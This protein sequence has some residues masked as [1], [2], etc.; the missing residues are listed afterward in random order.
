MKKLILLIMVSLLPMVC[1]AQLNVTST[2]EKMVTLASG[3]MGNISMVK[4]GDFY[5]MHISSSNQ[6][7]TPQS[8]YL[9]DSAESCKKTLNDLLGLID[10]MGKDERVQVDNKGKKVSLFKYS[11]I[12]LG[13]DF[14]NDAGMFWISKQEC[15]KFLSAME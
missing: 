4:M 3:R 10:T 14:G 8:F 1:N 6:F 5:F 2:S 7:E 9:G 15:K 11:N 13:F 12:S